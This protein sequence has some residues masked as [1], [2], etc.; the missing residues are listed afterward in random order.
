M[1][2]VIKRYQLLTYVQLATSFMVNGTS[3][4]V[5]FKGGI[6]RPYLVRGRFSTDNPSLQEAIETDAS[7]G[8]LFYLECTYGDVPAL[9]EAP[10]VEET[11]APETETVTEEVPET[12]VPEE[13]T[14]V[15]EAPVEE[16]KA[17]ET[18][19]VEDSKP[20]ITDYPEVTN[21]QEA[22][23]K[24]FELFPGEFKPANMPNKPAVLNKAKDKN[25]TF[26]KLV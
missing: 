2:K 21:L 24:M 1:S 23:Q 10:K 16:T 19:Q 25:I 6:T 3:I 12:E 7:F 22:R 4:P 18:T 15:P 20:V 26:S 5:T 9:E 8:K 13:E 14:T 17:P 11:V